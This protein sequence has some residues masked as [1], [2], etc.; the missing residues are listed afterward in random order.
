MKYAFFRKT[1]HGNWKSDEFFAEKCQFSQNFAFK[2]R[3]QFSQN[4]DTGL[5]G[6]LHFIFDRNVLFI[7]KN[8]YFRQFLSRICRFNHFR[9]FCVILARML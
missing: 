3:I 6:H 8:E 4:F 7:I 2:I 5:F 1:V 9:A